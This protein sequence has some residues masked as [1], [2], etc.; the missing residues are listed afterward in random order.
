M[1]ERTMELAGENWR[2][3][4]LDRWGM[5]DNQTD[6]NWL[7]E[8]DDEFLNFKVGTHNRYPIPY[9]EIPLVPGL[10]QNPGF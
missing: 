5:F 6:I 8:R 2:W 10:M 1:H 9:R 7:S 3:L 4:D